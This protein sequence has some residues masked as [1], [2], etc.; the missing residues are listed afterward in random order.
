MLL[1][2]DVQ[3]RRISTSDFYLYEIILFLYRGALEASVGSAFQH[4]SGSALVDAV[5]CDGDE[6]SLEYCNHGNWGEATCDLGTNAA[7]VKC[8][9]TK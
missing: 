8:K 6:T 1:L 9:G 7:G 2:L 5:E 3:A 4:T